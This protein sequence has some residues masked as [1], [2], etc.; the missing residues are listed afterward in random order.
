MMGRSTPGRPP[1]ERTRA[2]ALSSVH[3]RPEL[4]DHLDPLQRAGGRRECRRGTG[5]EDEEPRKRERRDRDSWSGLGYATLA[6]TRNRER[7]RRGSQP[8]GNNGGFS[9]GL[10]CRRKFRAYFG[11]PR[12]RARMRGPRGR[13][14]APAR[15][16]RTGPDAGA[17][18]RPA[19]ARSAR[20]ATT[21]S[22]A[23]S[24]PIACSSSAVRAGEVAARLACDSTPSDAHT[25]WTAIGVASER[26]SAAAAW[27]VYSS[28]ITPESGPGSRARNGS[29]PLILG[30]SIALT[31][32]AISDA[33][34]ANAARTR[35]ERGPKFGGMEVAGRERPAFVDQRILRARVELARDHPSSAPRRRGDAVDL[36]QHAERIR[37]LDEPVG[38]VGIEGRTGEQLAHPRGDRRLTAGAARR[39][40][41]GVEHDGI[42]VERLERQRRHLEPALEERPR[43]DGQQRGMTGGHRVRADEAERVAEA[44]LDRLAR[45]RAHRR[46]RRR[47]TPSP[48]RAARARSRT[49]RAGRRCRASRT[50]G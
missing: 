16:R 29:S 42:G 11:R 9:H 14:E 1:S 40:D 28:I 43:V 36:R 41:P 35:V 23:T 25:L 48:P 34:C 5:D 18:G 8:R 49:A 26:A 39:L 2:R 45:A 31:R 12:R 32:P 13:P 17:G 47:A 24:T 7:R 33:E 6:W 46:A 38:S 4:D 19:P 44:E 15:R 10:S 30:S 27:A 20:T 22:V 37:I 50:R 21:S 3:A